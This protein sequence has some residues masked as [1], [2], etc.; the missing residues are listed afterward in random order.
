MK[1]TQ[2]ARN[3]LINVNRFIAFDLNGRGG[4]WVVHRWAPGLSDLCQ[5]TCSNGLLEMTRLTRVVT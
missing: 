3:D 1:S 5:V 4:G 2:D